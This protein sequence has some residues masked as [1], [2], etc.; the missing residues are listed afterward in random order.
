VTGATGAEALVDRLLADT[1][2]DV[3]LDDYGDPSFRD[4]LERLGRAVLATADLNPVGEAAFEG[5]VKGHLANR[6]RVT[7]WHRT[8]PEVGDEVVRAP[9]VITGLPR[10]GTTALS[11]LLACDPGNRSLLGWEAG[12]SVPPPRTETYWRDPRLTAAR[13]ASGMMDLLN[14]GFKAIHHD[15][16]DKPTECVVLFAQQFQSA[17]YPTEFTIP[18]YDEWM[19][20][21]DATAAYAYHRAVLQV[22]QS[23]CPGR[24]QLKTPQHGLDL[25]AL[26]ATYPDARIV[27]THRDPVKCVASVLS[28]VRS[29]SGTFTDVDHRGYIAGHWPELMAE[30]ANRPVGFRARRPDVPVHDMSYEDLVGDPVDAIR[31]MYATFGEELSDDAADAMAAYSNESP[32]GAHGR[33]EYRLADF[34]LTRGDVEPRFEPYLARHDVRREEA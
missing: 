27:I 21:A 13:E 1:A 12:R 15:P 22:L 16:P 3:G 18:E 14:P 7:D 4:G 10:T 25:D 24:W 34:G 17:I 33:H 8:H 20:G 6:L 30:F 9:I 2:A 32:Q 23:E 29:L 11:H 31:A 28:L 5:Q 19:L 26:L